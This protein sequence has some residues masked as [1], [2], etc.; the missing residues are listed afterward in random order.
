[1][2]RFA[3]L[4]PAPLATPKFAAA[5]P[6][7]A[8]HGSQRVHLH[9]KLDEFAGKGCATAEDSPFVSEISRQWLGRQTRA[10]SS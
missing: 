9:A 4:L 6:S 7:I 2:N 1:M 8:L 5:D 3:R 10:H